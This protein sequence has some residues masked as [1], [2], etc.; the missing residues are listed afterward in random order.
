MLFRRVEGAFS[1]ICLSARPSVR[2]LVCLSVCL[3]ALSL[4]RIAGQAPNGKELHEECVRKMR[5]LYYYDCLR[6][7]KASDFTS[8]PLLPT[9]PVPSAPPTTASTACPAVLSPLRRR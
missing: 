3:P 4:Y 9:V 2:L 5:D 7:N 6:A 1:S 8:R